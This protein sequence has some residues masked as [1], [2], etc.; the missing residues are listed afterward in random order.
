MKLTQNW[1]GW[2]DRSYEQIKRALLS[3]LTIANP[4]LTDHSED[5]PLIILI[6]I[7]AGIA[8]VLHL[9]IDNL[10]REV[11][12]GTARKFSSMLRIVKL[13][14][15]RV[16]TR[17]PAYADLQMTLYYNGNVSSYPYGDIILPTNSIILSQPGQLKFVTQ[18]DAIIKPGYTSVLFPARQYEIVEDDFLGTADGVALF[19]VPLPENYVHNSLSLSVNGVAYKE[20]DTFAYMKINTK[21]FIVDLDEEGNA[22]AIFGDGIN[23]VIPANGDDIVGTYKICDG[24]DGNLPPNSINLLANNI[25]LPTGYTIAITNPDFSYSGNEF[26]SLDDIRNLSPRHLSTLRRAVSYRD[27]IDLALLSPGVGQAELSYCCADDIKLWITPRTRGIAGLWL[28][29]NTE[30]YFRDKKIVGRRISVLPAGITRIWVKLGIKGNVGYTESQIKIASILA[31]NDNYGFNAQKINA[32]IALSDIVALLDDL[33]TNDRVDL[34]R[35]YIEPY[36]RPTKETTPPLLINWGQ[37]NSTLSIIYRIIYKSNNN[38]PTFDIYK[39][40]LPYATVPINTPWSD[41]NIITFT[42]LNNGLYNE[43]DEW[44]FRVYPTYPELFNDYLIDIRDNTIPIIDVDL[45]NIDGQQ[46]PYIFSEIEVEVTQ[47]NESLCKPSC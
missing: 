45:N 3:R 10:G 36:A 7:F 9:Y 28:R 39:N 33:P 37:V 46:I 18:E 22:F 8:E 47:T 42:I 5:N 16:K 4:E 30:I 44:V 2:A 12:I 34:K 32:T 11:Y 24:S 15:Y 26:E 21:G 19:M 17:I 25:S 1:V 41:A 35:V 14:D 23:G 27:Y 6:S 40:N 31:L 38:N 43:D 13:I 20:Y 29:N